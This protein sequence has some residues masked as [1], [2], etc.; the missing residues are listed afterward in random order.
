MNLNQKN[1]EIYYYININSEDIDTNVIEKYIK[2]YF[3]VKEKRISKTERFSLNK[4]L[5]DDDTIKCGLK[6]F[7]LM[8]DELK[9]KANSNTTEVWFLYLSNGQVKNMHNVDVVLLNNN[10]TNKETLYHV[11]NEDNMLQIKKELSY[12]EKINKLQF[13]KKYFTLLF[14]NNKIIKYDNLM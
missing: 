14:S 1:I 13:L 12:L 10:I 8:L 6:I 3:N 9:L 2:V 5:K 4:E 7:N 11:Y